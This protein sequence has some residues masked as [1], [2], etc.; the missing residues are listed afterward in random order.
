MSRPREFDESAVID[1]S[2]RAFWA[3]GL[4]QTSVDTLL[5]TTGL[6]RSSL[7]SCIGNRDELLRLAVE[8]YVDLQLAA[9]RQLFARHEPGEALQTLFV[10]AASTNLEGRGCLLVNGANELHDA[11]SANREAVRRGFGRIAAELE[12]LLRAA[13]HASPRDGCIEAMVAIA[14]L[15]TMQRAG[16]GRAGLVR[17]ARRFASLI[18][19]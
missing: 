1:A 8:R 19:P 7:Y 3:G 18:A 6:S 11:E 5:Q 10:E 15:R 9:L 12:K 17:A 14:G 13:G 16:L 2:V 4:A